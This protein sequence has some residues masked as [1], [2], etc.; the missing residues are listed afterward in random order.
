M[1]RYGIFVSCVFD[2]DYDVRMRKELVFR[3]FVKLPRVGVELHRARIRPF[4]ASVG[5]FGEDASSIFVSC[6]SH[7][8]SV[9]LASSFRASDIFKHVVFQASSSRVS[10]IFKHAVFQASSRHISGIFKSMGDAMFTFGMYAYK[11]VVFVY[12]LG[13]IK[14]GG[15]ESQGCLRGGGHP[16]EETRTVTHKDSRVSLNVIQGLQDGLDG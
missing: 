13:E 15:C 5:L 7:L 12:S 2:P 11:R 6:S 9:F 4:E 3:G 10:S 1:S 14:G 8:H 16:R